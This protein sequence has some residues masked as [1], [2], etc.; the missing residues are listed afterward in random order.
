MKVLLATDFY[1]PTINGVVISVL[2]LRSELLKLGHEVKI[3]T[4]SETMISH[5]EDGVIYI[6]SVGIGKIYPGLRITLPRDNQFI[7]DLIRWKPDVIHSQNE[8]STFY[9][10]QQIA[11]KL[12][13]PVVHTYH[14]V[15]E[16]YTHYFSPVETW[17]KSLS[18]RFTNRSLKNVD[19]V[20]A[21]TEKVSNLLKDYGVQREI[22]IAPTGIHVRRL[23]AAL[24]LERSNLMKDKIG[25]SS[26][27]KIL[28]FVGRLAKEKNLEEIMVYLSRLSRKDLMLL[29]VGGG[30]YSKALEKV[31][32]ELNIT[33]LVLFV[34]MVPQDEIGAY[35]QM[36]D[37]FVSASNSE[38]QGLT[39]IEALAY[40]IPVLCRRD[41]CL[42]NVVD[43]GINGWQYDTFQQFRTRLDEILTWERNEWQVNLNKGTLK[44]FSSETFG[45]KM[46]GIY[47]KTIDQYS[48]QTKI[49]QLSMAGYPE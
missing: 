27:K 9:I 20:I 2:N 32:A 38:T 47:I 40:G 30:P 18:V 35:Y 24:E 6:G 1:T 5:E 45:K 33:D 37:V 36:G 41:P 15:Y 8:F 13:I 26:D 34:G 22:Q 11:K 31:A 46:E 14:T 21:P 48:K 23:K 10:A 12:Q 19:C 16:K 43:D 44:G 49:Q 4:L 25:I 7:E 29:I 17:G 3:L 39:Y 28:V 42:N